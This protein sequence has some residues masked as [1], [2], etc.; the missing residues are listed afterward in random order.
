VP[1]RDIGIMA[2]GDLF[3]SRVSYG[4]GVFNG[5]PDGGST[6]GDTQDGKDFAARL[7]A[8]PFRTS[9]NASLQGLGFGVAGSYGIQRG[10]VALPDLPTFKS[11]GQLTFFRFRGDATEAGTAV[12]G[13]RH[14]RLSTQGSYYRGSLGVIGEQVW[15]SHEVRRATA[16]T[17]LDH[18]A[19]QV[20]ASYVLTGEKASGRAIAPRRAFDTKAGTWGAF[21]LTARANGLSADPAAFPV[22]ANPQVSA[23]SAKAW[24]VGANWYLNPS[25]KCTLDYELTRFVGGAV[26]GNR[27]AEHD[28]LSRFQISF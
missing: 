10:N 6:D 3:K 25:V 17:T 19:W 2:R 7:F 15:S 24:A 12:A 27:P 13:G 1:N 22:F 20:A 21:E 4:A 26:S 14:V 18:Q 5:V 9:A 28:V 23:R 16:A 8:Q 11:D